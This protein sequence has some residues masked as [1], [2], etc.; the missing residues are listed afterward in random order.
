MRLLFV[1]F[2]SC[3]IYFTCDSF[4]SANEFYYQGDYKEALDQYQKCEKNP[5]YSLYY[6]LGNVYFKLQKYGLSRYNYEMAKVLSPT[7]Q[8]LKYNLSLLKNKLNDDVDSKLFV[9]STLFDLE[10]EYLL[11]ILSVLFSISFLYRAKIG[12]YL[13]VVSLVFI[14]LMVVSYQ[15]LFFKSVRS[16]I[17]LPVETQIYSSQDISSAVLGRV[18]TGYKV[19][20]VQVLKDWVLVEFRLNNS[21]WVPA[22]EIA[23]IGDLNELETISSE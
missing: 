9:S 20:I 3:S 18:H 8:N 6:N 16:G 15:S 17:I 11:I 10:V 23:I 14:I 21:G 2:L 22:Q 12:K 1:F 5:S 7:N 13:W 4:L 19:K